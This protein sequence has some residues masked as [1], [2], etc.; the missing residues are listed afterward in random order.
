VPK[1]PVQFTIGQLP[2]VTITMNLL[3]FE[4]TELKRFIDEAQALTRTVASGDDELINIKR[5]EDQI[6]S[7]TDLEGR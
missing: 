5:L 7:A 1:G 2:A 4:P 6:K 3:T